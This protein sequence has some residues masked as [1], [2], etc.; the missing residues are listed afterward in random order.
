MHANGSILL[1]HFQFGLAHETMTYNHRFVRPQSV[2]QLSI[3]FVDFG[4][5]RAK[6]SLRRANIRD[7]RTYILKTDSKLYSMSEQ[8]VRRLAV[9]RTIIP[10]VVH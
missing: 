7:D 3:V 2:V 8:E 6:H 9:M 5:D 10:I 1:E 4:A